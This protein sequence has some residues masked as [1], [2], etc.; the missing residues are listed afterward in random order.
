MA[1]RLV[2]YMRDTGLQS[3]RGLTPEG[4]HVYL[5]GDIIYTNVLFACSALL[6]RQ[7]P[8]VAVLERGHAFPG[9]VRLQRQL[10]PV[11]RGVPVAHGTRVVLG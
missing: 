11:S 7:S 8:G 9:V 4:S 3:V 1:A 2:V 5:R 10:V 6:Q